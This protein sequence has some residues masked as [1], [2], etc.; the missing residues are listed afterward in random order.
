M[1]QLSFSE[2][3]SKFLKHGISL[4]HP[5][6]IADKADL[7]IRGRELLPS[8]ILKAYTPLIAQKAMKG[9]V[10]RGIHDRKE[11]RKGHREKLDGATELGAKALRIIAQDRVLEAEFSKSSASYLEKN[12]IPDYNDVRKTARVMA[13]IAGKARK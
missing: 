2:R 10:W 1:A 9:L 11:L 6:P 3:N 8:A 13:A 7:L 5:H 4:F 12:G